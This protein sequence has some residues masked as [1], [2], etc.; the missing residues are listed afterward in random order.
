MNN[1]DLNYI[2]ENYLDIREFLY[3]PIIDDELIKIEMK[4]IF[5]KKDWDSIFI[6][7]DFFLNDEEGCL[8]FDFIRSLEVGS[9]SDN[10]I[11]I[12]T[13]FKDIWMESYNSDSIAKS[14]RDEWQSAFSGVCFFPENEK[15]FALYVD[16]PYSDF[17][18]LSS[19]A[20]FIDDIKNK[21]DPK[22]ILF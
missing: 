2:S 1:V 18:V 7:P 14:D 3:S 5:K 4:S 21:I 9:A 8:G 16:R 15:W 22:W 13:E 11:F 17:I 19:E 6:V 12:L 20:K 10:V